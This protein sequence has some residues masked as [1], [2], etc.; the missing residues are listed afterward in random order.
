MVAAN[1]ISRIAFSIDTVFNNCIDNIAR[2]LVLSNS[3]CA[4]LNKIFMYAV[5]TQFEHSL[6]SLFSFI[7]TSFGNLLS[8][9]TMFFNS[10]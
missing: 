7:V 9:I 6:R 10:N 4:I 2:T 1:E 3:Y 5:I 8:M